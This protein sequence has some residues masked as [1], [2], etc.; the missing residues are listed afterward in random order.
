MELRAARAAARRRVSAYT[1]TVSMAGLTLLVLAA[2]AA[3][4]VAGRDPE[5]V[6][7]LATLVLAAEL[8]PLELGRLRG[9]PGD[10][11]GGPPENPT[12]DS[13]TMSQ[14]FAFALVLGWG[15]PAGVV[16]LGACS[17]LA[18]LLAGKAAR[19][20]L[21][22]S[23]QLATALGAAGMAYS[24]AGGHP[25]SP[26]D[27]P[28]GPPNPPWP[29]QVSL[30]AFAVAALAFFVVNNLLVEAV[31]VLAGGTPALGRVRQG[32]GVRA[33]VS[34][35]LLGMAPVVTVIAETSLGL[36][37]ILGLPTAAVYLACRGAIQADRERARAEA[38][39]EQAQASAAEQAR[40][41]EGEQALIRQLQ[42]SDR[43]KRDLLATVSHELKTPLTVIL[44]TLGTLS[45]R[46]AALEPA[47][48]R[49]FVDMAIRQG[50]RL[51]KLIEQLL[52]AARFEQTGQEPAEHP[53]VD[54]AALARDALAAARVA[55]P[56]RELVLIAREVLPVR[57]APEAVLQ[58]LGNLLD[59]AAK[60]SPDHGPV[61]LEAT[62]YGPLA[63]LA[64]EDTGPGVP[65]A[66]R[67]RIFERFTQLDSG[68]T[69][70]A[71]GVGLGLYI[72]RQLA[73]A[74]DGELIVCDPPLGG[75][76]ARFE[77]RL[78]LTP[79]APSPN[80]VAYAA[81]SR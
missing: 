65:P 25:G 36:V 11:R 18:D 21:F 9:G 35:M 54:A 50:T 13:T 80:P 63:V 28:G 75:H 70:R 61:R 3:A 57:A 47:E 74:Q 4:R 72:A 58:V 6:L 76:G 10:R 32:V 31:L 43:L 49:E 39:A 59:N 44:G 56:G 19:K 17:A 53:L 78:P 68:A 5:P 46:G 26:G 12:G 24:L 23:A 55:H 79:I 14:P 52:L 77:L 69:R 67:E 64:V 62:R 38:E 81:S 60:Y 20:V 33:W 2:P 66:D 45:R 16:A 15:T 41:V 40:L 48:R 8:M 37:P 7:L 42:E 34:A 51:K 29:G 73:I 1:T 27:Q 22:N 71:G 30:P